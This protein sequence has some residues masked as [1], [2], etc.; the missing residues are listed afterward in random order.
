MSDVNWYQDKVMAAVKDAEQ[1][2]LLALAFQVEAEAK[3]NAPV[4]TGFM[5]NSSYVVGAGQN[6]FVPRH[7]GDK[8]TTPS[9]ATPQDD[10]E[11]VIG[12]AAD[13]TIYVESTQPFI[14]PALQSVVAQ[15]GGTIQAAGANHL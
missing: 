12:F 7:D 5:R 10:Q 9:P 15:A 11:V 14:Y 4:D 6:T 13:Y 8:E 2:F 1:E 3:V